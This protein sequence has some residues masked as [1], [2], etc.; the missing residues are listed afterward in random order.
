[1]I[2]ISIPGREMKLELQNLVLDLNGTLT[3]DGTL[4]AGVGARIDMLKENLQIYLL[5]SDTLGCGAMVA[6]EL[7]IS[8]FKV[9]QTNGGAD[10]LDFLNT[11][12]AEASTVIGNGFNDRLVL[13]HAALSIAVIGAE[14]SCVQ[15]LQKADIVAN[16][17]LDA[18]DLLLYPM[19]IVATLRD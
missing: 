13:E 1:M 4:I 15:A 5:T 16:N 7:G 3:V 8:I 2:D 6:E 9:G 18:L 10:K 14:G 19:R 12:G 11:I 17:I